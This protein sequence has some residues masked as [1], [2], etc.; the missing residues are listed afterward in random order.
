[1]LNAYPFKTS[2]DI[3][4]STNNEQ[5]T[6]E[7]LYA[8]VS[9][10]VQYLKGLN[11][12]RVALLADNCVEWVYFDLACQ[13]ADSVLIPIPAFFSEEQR[14]HLLSSADVQ[15]VITERSEANPVTGFS[16]DVTPLSPGKEDALIPQGTAK[17]TFTSGSTG[18]PKGVCLSSN[19]QFTVADSLAEAVN[20]QGV[21]H[22]TVLP[23]S[24]L[25]ENIA[26]IYS[27]LLSGGQ[28]ILATAPERGFDGESL[29]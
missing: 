23:L 9:A 26:G 8:A 6:Y 24:L 11:A 16:V 1:M 21:K 22:L 7:Q 15:F 2:C 5:V 12:E 19:A 10:R 18:A 25:L 14:E 17:I 27:P 29:S 4:I 20:I 28:V 13:F 3:A